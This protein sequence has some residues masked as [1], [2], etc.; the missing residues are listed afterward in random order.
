[1]KAADVIPPL[2]F[3]D[4]YAILQ[5][6]I[7]TLAAEDKRY[8]ANYAAKSTFVLNEFGFSA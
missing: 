3:S 5:S 6:V 8:F 7:N 4:T 2:L 1:M